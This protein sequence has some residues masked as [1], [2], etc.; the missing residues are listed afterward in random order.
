MVGAR[1]E[2]VLLHSFDQAGGKAGAYIAGSQVNPRYSSS[3]RVISGIVTTVGAAGSA[4]RTRMTVIYAAPYSAAIT[5]AT[6]V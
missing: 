2:P 3:S 5:A 4:G 1:D 6:K